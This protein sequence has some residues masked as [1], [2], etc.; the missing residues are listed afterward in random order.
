MYKT[1]QIL[2]SGE[3]KFTSLTYGEAVTGPADD[4]GNRRVEALSW[5]GATLEYDVS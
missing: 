3:D 1:T 5:R 4:Y 2:S